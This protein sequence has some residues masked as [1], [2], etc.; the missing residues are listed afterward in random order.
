MIKPLPPSQEKTLNNAALGQK[1]H[2]RSES[3]VAFGSASPLIEETLFI[4]NRVGCLVLANVGQSRA[5]ILGVLFALAIIIAIIGGNVYV[6]LASKSNPSLYLGLVD[7]SAHFPTG[8]VTA[9]FAPDAAVL[10]GSQTFEGWGI[11]FTLTL[12]T[13]F[14]LFLVTSLRISF[15]DI[16]FRSVF[17]GLML[18]VI[19]IASNAFTLVTG[20]GYFGPSTVTFAS[21]GLVLGFGILNTGVWVGRNRPGFQNQGYREYIST[22]VSIATVFTLVY[23]P[24]VFP[25]TFFNIPSAYNVDWT[26]YVFCFVFGIVGSFWYY[27]TREIS[28]IV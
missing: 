17:Y 15:R 1:S 25:F 22:I 10:S 28:N 20:Q 4:N 26:A 18:V 23:L 7:N 16:G 19:P 24:L 5:G 13:L 6:Y 12:A 11:G 9:I 2:I 14:V 8:I 3:R 21:M 27:T